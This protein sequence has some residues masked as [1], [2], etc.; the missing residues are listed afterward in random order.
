MSR[1]WRTGLFAG[2]AWLAIS[3]APAMAQETQAG[4]DDAE[5]KEGVIVVTAQRREQSI[6]EIPF[7]VN[8]VDADALA[9]AGVT[10]VFALQTKVPGLDIRT[11]NPPS[12]GGAFSI[13]GLGT[14]VS[15]LGF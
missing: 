3:A 4:A 7:T 13:R 14:G 10:D 11:T 1:N 8:A 9:N 2:S 12:A 15:N 5:A 6:Q